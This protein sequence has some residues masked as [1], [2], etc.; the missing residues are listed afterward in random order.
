MTLKELETWIVR[1]GEKYPE[2]VGLKGWRENALGETC[3]LGQI[4]I[5]SREGAW[6]ESGVSGSRLDWDVAALN[7]VGIPWGKIPQALGLV[8]GEQPAEPI[9][10]PVEVA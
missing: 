2:R 9:A 6:F 3:I 5:E 7:N 10:E 8:P 4:G 1:M